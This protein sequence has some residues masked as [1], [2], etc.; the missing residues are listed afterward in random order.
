MIA[1]SRPY[2]SPYIRDTSSSS[3][4]D[5][6]LFPGEAKRPRSQTR[7]VKKE[8][9]KRDSILAASCRLIP[10][11]SDLISLPLSL[12]QPNHELPQPEPTGFVFPSR[13]TNNSSYLTEVQKNISHTRRFIS[14][15]VS[16]CTMERKY[17]FL[18]V[19][20]VVFIFF[21]F[22]CYTCTLR[23]FFYSSLSASHFPFLQ[24]SSLPFLKI[25]L[26]FPS[27][28]LFLSPSSM[29]CEV[30]TMSFFT[31]FFQASPLIFFPVL[32]TFEVFLTSNAID[33]ECRAFWTGRTSVV[34]TRDNI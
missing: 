19:C 3:H 25:L 10:L 23:T 33:V 17:H 14:H 30:M 15:L 24:I 18:R 6:R 20:F 31:H 4:L 8:Q 22:F 26:I 29:A 7:G 5:Y 13:S 2:P 12:S 27:I 11:E 32:L 9:S 21:F 28:I 34:D 16:V 1:C